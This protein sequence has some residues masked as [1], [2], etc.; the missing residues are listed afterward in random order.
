MNTTNINTYTIK[1]LEH[2][3]LISNN[4]TLK[5]LCRQELN[6]RLNLIKNLIRKVV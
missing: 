6:R 1:D 4:E 2:I 5:H 3:L